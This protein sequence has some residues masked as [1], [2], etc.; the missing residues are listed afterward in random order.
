MNKPAAADIDYQQR[1][2]Q[3]VSRTFALTIPQLPE[4]LALVVGNAYLLCRIADT[5]ED[6]PGLSPGERR[7]R[8]MEF[9]RLVSGEPGA[10]QFARAQADLA[11]RVSPAEAELLAHVPQ[12]LR[13]T[14]SFR[15][16]QRRI[17]ERCV[18][19]MATGMSRHQ[20]RAS[21]RGLPDMQSVDDY[22][23]H[24][25]GVVGEM[26]T[27]LFCDYSPAVATHR[28]E[29]MRL[30]VSFGQGLQMTNILKDVWEDRRRGACWLPQELFRAAGLSL[31][32][33][34]P[35][36]AAYQQTLRQLVGIAGGHL[37][38]ALCYTL[39]VPPAEPGIRR[40]CLWAVGMA[41]LTLQKINKNPGYRSGREA[42]I[43]R[44]SVY[45]TIFL[46]RLFA[47]SDRMLRLLFRLAA[48]GLSETSVEPGAAIRA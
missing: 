40:F 42:K 18:R 12:V 37:D 41:V 38:N 22:C 30:A 46:I 35:D 6:A 3:E 13:I 28:D 11:D 24:V 15:H 44:R 5:I 1:S 23:Y 7:V 16:E 26:L 48:R 47:G 45:A 17:L 2:L 25:A 29:L 4:P 20:Q 31:E 10:E 36:N 33:A 21:N 14:H 32:D 19:I 9:I 34:S 8:S 27:E 39:L 43:S